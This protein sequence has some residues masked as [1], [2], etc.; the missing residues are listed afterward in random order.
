M[1]NIRFFIDFDG[2]VTNTDA[3]D[4]ILEKF[5]NPS[6]RQIEEEWAAGRI[7]SRECLSKQVALVRATKAQLQAHIANIEVDPFFEKFLDFMN[8][9]KISCSIVSDGFDFII[10]KILQRQLRPELLET[11]PV[12]AN[13]LEWVG[14][15][16]MAYFSEG[17]LC[18]HGCANCKPR[19]IEK[20][21]S[22]KDEVIFVGDGLSDRFA[23]QIANLTFAK[24]K[25]LV[26]CRKQKISH[27]AYHNFEEILEWVKKNRKVHHEIH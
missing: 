2:T 27:V 18:E 25:L 9:E 19:V 4:S 22:F 3:I 6:W 15:R 5:G 20:I 13:R 21:K 10:H 8:E 16:P 11:L 24:S 1:R 7:G 23:A 26:Y 14:D 12:Y 17:V